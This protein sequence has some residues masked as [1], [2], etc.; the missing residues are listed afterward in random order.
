MAIP[1]FPTASEMLMR[2]KYCEILPFTQGSTYAIPNVIHYR[3]NGMYRPAY[4]GSTTQP[5][6]FDQMNVLYNHFQVYG[7]K[8][9][10]KCT[11]DDGAT[12]DRIIGIVL[13][14]GAE[15][16][17]STA[18]LME[19]PYSVFKVLP[20][21]DTR[22]ITVSKNFSHKKFFRS[23]PGGEKSLYRGDYSTDPQELAYY[24]IWHAT[25][26]TSAESPNIRLH[27]TIEYVAKW[28]ERKI[29]AQS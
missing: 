27:L 26:A 3:A 6:F 2:H 8:I 1:R 25:S 4:S 17:G 5:L 24:S 15:L 16:L 28:S 14:P 21:S 10:L 11:L 19:Q 13:T 22:T 20:A 29:V 23:S 18:T 9:T 7:S 12:V